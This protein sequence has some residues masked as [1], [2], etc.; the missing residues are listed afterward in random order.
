MAS[1]S[2]DPRSEYDK[3]IERAIARKLV[4]LGGKWWR[5]ADWSKRRVYFDEVRYRDESR[6]RPRINR[7]TGFFDL[8]ARRFVCQYPAGVSDDKFRAIV[9]AKTSPTWAYDQDTVEYMPHEDVEWKGID[10]M[11][12][13]IAR[14]DDAILLSAPVL[15]RPELDASANVGR[16]VYIDRPYYGRR[17]DGG[18]QPNLWSVRCS[19]EPFEISSEST[20]ARCRSMMIYGEHLMRIDDGRRSPESTPAPTPTG[21]PMET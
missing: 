15:G 18:W 20:F 9:L 13:A 8:V 10:A 16:V 7:A 1:E 12:A 3:L 21:Q 2:A 4:A 14:A 11:G 19:G 17:R 6:A 5:S